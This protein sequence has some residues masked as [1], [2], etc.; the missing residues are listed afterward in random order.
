MVHRHVWEAEA[1]VGP[2][3]GRRQSGA[4]VLRGSY[5]VLA[6]GRR[7]CA[8]AFVDVGGV[9][10]GLGVATSHQ[11][12]RMFAEFLYFGKIYEQ[13]LVD[14]TAELDCEFLDMGYLICNETNES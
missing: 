10:G 6:L 13:R 11:G 8:R 7:D 9:V 14:P 4:V 12:E 5:L 3:R 1:G 2:C